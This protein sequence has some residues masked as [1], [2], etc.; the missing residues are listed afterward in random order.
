MLNHR[1]LSIMKKPWNL[2]MLWNNSEFNENAQILVNHGTRVHM[3]RAMKYANTMTHNLESKHHTNN[4]PKNLS[5]PPTATKINVSPYYPATNTQV[6]ESGC[7]GKSHIYHFHNTVHK[8]S[9][10]TQKCNTMHFTPLSSSERV[11]WSSFVQ[12]GWCWTMSVL[13]PVWVQWALENGSYKKKS[14]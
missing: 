4:N 7:I 5:L 11:A 8:D 2:Q 12:L 1:M 14:Q 13:S 6:M 10:I 9:T 3:Q